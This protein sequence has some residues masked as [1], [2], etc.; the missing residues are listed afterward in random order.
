MENKLKREEQDQGWVELMIEAK[1]LHL[2]V[3]DVRL[4]LDT[5]KD[6]DITTYKRKKCNGN[7][8]L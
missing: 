6:N 3:E 5:M 4:F 7:A 8:S 2:S 1:S